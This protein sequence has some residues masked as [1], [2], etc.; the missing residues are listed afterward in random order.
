MTFSKK[1]ARYIVNM[2]YDHIPPDVLKF[3]KLCLLDYYASLLNG[4]QESPPR[5]MEQVIHILGGNEQATA[6]SGYKTSV[7]NAAFI[8]GGASH[9]IELDDIHKASIVH[10]ATVIMPAA[11]AVAEWKNCSGQQLLEAIIV[12]YEVAFRIGETVTPAHYYYFHN[13]ATCGTFGA[14]AAVC[15]LLQLNEEQIVHALGSAGTQAAG[16]WEFIEDGVMSKQLHPGN[17][18]VNG[19]ISALLAEVG[20]TGASAIL[21]GKRGFFEAMAK[22]YD[23]EKLTNDLEEQYKIIENSFKIHASCRHTHAA[24]DLALQVRNEYEITDIASIE[25]LT[26]E[27]A[28]TITNNPAPKTI[29]AAKFSIQFCVALAILKGTGNLQVFNEL[30]LNDPQI[31]SLMNDITVK[32]DERITNNYPEKWGTK[33]IVT[34]KNR[35]VWTVE[36]DYPKG[37][38]ENPLTSVDFIDKFQMLSPLDFTHN[39]K[40]IECILQIE[41]YTVRNLIQTIYA[42][43]TTA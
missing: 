33:L 42:E 38:P 8:N 43:S 24:M 21:E 2:K 30:S 37:D 39:E 1:F 17:A 6:A 20:F 18:G 26:Y 16:L 5:M 35:E 41:K 13:T 34:F 32:V 14:T 25:I 31:R 3:T 23:V 29:Y 27:V 12:G 9:V 19:I 15:K 7:T 40:I 22:T 10:A 11:L 36:T 28:D 4:I